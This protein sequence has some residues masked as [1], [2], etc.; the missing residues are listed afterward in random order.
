[1]R[2]LVWTIAFAAGDA[3]SAAGGRVVTGV[4]LAAA[5]VVLAALLRRSRASPGVILSA[6]FVVAGAQLGAR[7]ARPPVLPAALTSALDADRGAA[8][9]GIVARGPELTA[10][11]ARL[12]VEAQR[13][14][15]SPARATLSL[16]VAQGS[17]GDWPDSWRDLAPGATIA[18]EARLRSVRGTRNPGVPDPALALRAAG[19]DALA[20]LA[21]AARL[22]LLAAP[23]MA[24][25]RGLAYRAHRAL[26]AAIEGAVHGPAAAFLDTAV[27][28]ERRGV[29]PDV[30]DG[31]RAAGATHVLSVSGLHLA[32]IATLLFAF[33]RAAAARVPNL[34]LAID[35]RAV[36]AAVSLPAVGFFTLLTGEAVAT[37]RSALML[38]LGLLAILV[39]RAPRPAATIAGA[40]LILL[41]AQ[42]LQLFD[43]SFQ[44]SV[45]SVGGIAL[46]SR[47][48]GPGP[49]A[50]EISRPRRAARWLWRFGAA[51]LAATASTAPLVTHWFG[52]IAPSAPLGNLALVPLVELAVV[53]IGLAG[54]TLGAVWAPLGRWPLR[55]A[56]AAARLAL[57]IAAGFRAHAPVWLCRMPNWLETAAATAAGL[58]ALVALAA[59]GRRRRW[60]AWATAC[61]LL[62]AGSIAARDHLRR[63][64]TTLVATFLDV[65]QGDAAVVEA[66]GGAVMLIDGGGTRDGT[67]DTGAR[68]VEP[69]LRARGIGRLD[70]VAL[71]HPHPDHLNGLFR[72]VQRFPVGELWSSGDDGHNPEYRRLIQV[73][74]DR[75]IPLP[76]VRASPLGGAWV[77]PLA[78]IVD[79][80]VSPPPG[81]TVNDASLVLRVGAGDHALLF[82][83]DLEADGEGEL[84]G[85]PALGRAVTADV[86]KVPHHGSRTSSTDELLDAVRPRLAVMSLGWHNQFHFPSPEV[87]ARYAARGIATL[88]T[89]RD[90]AV[91][92]SLSPDGRL[93]VSCAR[94]CPP[95]PIRGATEDRP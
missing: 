95:Q 55:I 78:P 41:V 88:R 35:P 64:R 39:G 52:E 56:A 4:A 26:R 65:G 72:I 11:G 12:M 67:F 54:A 71:S 3:L 92:V 16:T 38:A 69:F 90:G 81:L 14:D 21:S 59:P 66:P 30:E 6:L 91:T 17:P 82:P 15:G 1:M 80:T 50:T 33:A 36:A 7:A 10:G 68:I 27:L 76:P 44:L 79:G 23:A 57:A 42:P 9:V 2:L 73:A 74:R 24:G 75:G 22:R 77:Q 85:Q 83:G 45:A 94:G 31:F 25:P 5:A 60:G 28:G 70:V 89:D 63:H 93:A 8:L 32:A 47:G 13:I 62:A 87:V 29:T 84:A 34:A 19:V 51:T 46:C 49:A 43:V 58:M 20:S 37:E 48:L 53:P 18:F 86:L 40:A 61:A